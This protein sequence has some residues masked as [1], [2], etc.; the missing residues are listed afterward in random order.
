VDSLRFVNSEAGLK[1]RLR[2]FNARVIV[3]GTIRTGDA[4]RIQA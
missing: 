2:G 4:V 1:L 3:P